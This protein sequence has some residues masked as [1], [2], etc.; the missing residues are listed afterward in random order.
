MLETFEVNKVLIIAPLRVARDTWPAEIEKW[1][2]LK[3]LDISIIVGD[4]KTRIAA[5][6][7]PAMIYIVN[8]ENIKWLVEYYEKNGMR[9][10]FGMVVIDELSSFKNYQSQ[11]FKFLRKVRPFVKRWVGLTGTPSSNGLMDLWAEIGILDGGE[12]LGKFIGR[13]REAYFKAGSMNPA[14]GIVFQYVPRQGAEEMIYQRISDIT[15]SMKALDYL[16]MPDCVPTRCEVEM[17]TQEREL[18]DMLRQD[19]LIPLKDGDIDAANA[20]SLTGKLLQMSNGAVYDENGK[21]RVIHDHKL[22]ALEDL[23]EAANGQP[24]L[25]AY[26]FKHDRERIINHLSK[27]KIKVR[28]IKSSK[29]DTDYPQLLPEEKWYSVNVLTCAAPNLRERPSNEMNAG[30]GDAA[31]HI[32][33]EDLQALHEKRMRKVL[34]IAWAKGNEV[35]ILGAF[36]CGA[37]RNPPAVVAQ[38]MKTVVQEYRMRFETIEFAVYCTTQ[39]DTN[40]RVIQQVLGGM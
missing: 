26:W 27:L 8:R 24:V 33:R 5:V 3:G 34:E 17:N 2:H 23:I 35:V 10:D 25:V 11:R 14:T 12:R 39:Y 21:A 15:I 13:Y 37:F 22:E 20:A 32:S 29:S 1:D 18:Y 16:N 6:H 9:W 30:D 7:H 36:G 4:V 38:A 28:D 40:Y 19:L 31:A